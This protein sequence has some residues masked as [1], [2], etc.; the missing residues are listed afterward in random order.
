MRGLPDS[1]GRNVMLR[2]A[3]WVSLSL[4]VGSLGNTVS[5]QDTHPLQAALAGL[6]TEDNDT[7]AETE[8]QRLFSSVAESN[9]RDAGEAFRASYRREAES[10][11]DCPMAGA[12]AGRA[13]DFE[14]VDNE[15]VLTITAFG[16]TRRMHMDYWLEPP[17]TFMPNPLGWSVGRWAGDM[18][19]VRTTR[20][21]EGAIRR[22]DRPLP[23]GG[24]IAQIIERYTLSKDENRLS[25]DI[26]LNDPE[27]YSF[28]LNVRHNYVRVSDISQPE[29]C[30]SG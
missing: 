22:G 26:N 11:A 29:E 8:E 6:W 27:Y 21:S 16:R 15:D 17:D 1:G 28:T 7:G 10:G 24:P 23:F 2:W 30:V 20:F 13:T 18:L 5:A 12:L 3:A 4:A 9:L 19:V 25:V 14:V